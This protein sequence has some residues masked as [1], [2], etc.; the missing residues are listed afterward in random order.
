MN[1][2]LKLVALLLVFGLSSVRPV[3]AAEGLDLGGM[4][5]FHAERG[6]EATIALTRVDDPSAFG[7][8]RA[9]SSIRSECSA[10]LVQ[11]FWPLTM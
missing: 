10:R 4:L 6:A 2:K 11:I 3:S 8:V 5:A 1:R 9:R 7:V